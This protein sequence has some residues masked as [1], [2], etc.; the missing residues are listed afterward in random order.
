MTSQ[1]LHL[2]V[3]HTDDHLAV[4]ES[5]RSPESEP[6]ARAYLSFHHLEALIDRLITVRDEI[7]DATM[8]CSF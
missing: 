4:L 1:V 6:L 8:P 7:F 5:R 3:V 2:R